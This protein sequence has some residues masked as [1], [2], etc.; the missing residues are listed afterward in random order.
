MSK[1]I[2]YICI[3]KTLIRNKQVTVEQ[4]AEI[5]SKN[6]KILL[7]YN[8][9]QKMDAEIK[10][11]FEDFLVLLKDVLKVKKK[12]SKRKIT[13]TLKNIDEDEIKKVD[14]FFVPILEVVLKELQ[15]YYNAEHLEIIKE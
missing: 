15:K 13:K 12:L 4:I 1:I 10:K 11:M 2:N 14:D 8:G 7:D 3:F 9:V 6:F 5:L